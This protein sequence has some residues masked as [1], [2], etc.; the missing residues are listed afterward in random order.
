MASSVFP[1]V[2]SG[3]LLT[4]TPDAA[5][6]GID[7]FEYR[8]NDGLVDSNTARVQVSVFDQ[9]R[10]IAQQLGTDIDGEARDDRSG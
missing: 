7:A 3:R 1:A 10:A 6:T 8:V 9:Y 4:Y 5:F 2:L